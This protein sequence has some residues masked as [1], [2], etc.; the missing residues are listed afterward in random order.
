MKKR[1]IF[2]LAWTVAFPLTYFILSILMFATIGRLDILPKLP[3]HLTPEAMTPAAWHVAIFGMI[4]VALFWLSPVV[5]LILGI[6]G[7]LPGTRRQKTEE[8]P[9][10]A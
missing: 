10:D 6:C 8:R 9:H 4:W 5:G 7:V 3:P 1:V 2:I